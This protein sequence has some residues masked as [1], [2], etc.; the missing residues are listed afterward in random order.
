MVLFLGALRLFVLAATLCLLEDLFGFTSFGGSWI[1]VDP[2]TL[3]PF[4]ITEARALPRFTCLLP[5]NLLSMPDL[6]KVLGYLSF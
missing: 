1:K 2:H 6:L 3:T 4:S 5:L